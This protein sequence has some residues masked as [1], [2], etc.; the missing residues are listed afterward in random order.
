MLQLNPSCPFP[1]T[2]LQ[3]S[4]RALLRNL[5]NLHDDDDDD[6][7]GNYNDDA[8]GDDYADSDDDEASLA[9]VLRHA[10]LHR[11]DLGKA[12]D[13]DGH[14]DHND[15][16]DDDNDYEDD[17]DFDDSDDDDTSLVGVLRHTELHRLDQHHLF[18]QV[19]TAY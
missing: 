4:I 2:H 8:N 6:D 19:N 15:Y 5:G 18:C 9:G 17:D 7:D 12:D 10:E 11:L 13:F 14:Y 16:D 1:F 3:A